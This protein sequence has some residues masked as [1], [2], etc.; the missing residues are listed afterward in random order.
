MDKF[1][2]DIFQVPA[3]LIA[4]FFFVSILLLNYFGYSLRKKIAKKNPERELELGT[5]EGS[6]LGLMGL[7]LAFSFG[8]A[9]TKYEARRQTIVDEANL[10]STAILRSELFPD[11]IRQQL[12]S[13]LRN[14]LEYRI[15]YFQAGDKPEKIQAS[16]KNAHHQ[17]R[18]LYSYSVFLTDNN[19]YRP[20]AEQ[21]IS[22]LISMRTIMVNR[23]AGRVAAVPGLIIIV[24]LLLVF[25]AS[26]LTGIGIKPGKRSPFL[27]LAFAF[28]TTVVLYLVMEL[29]RPREGI[30]N[31]QQAE[32]NL[33]DLRTLFTS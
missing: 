12:H 17:F 22:A 9:A 30:V 11:S 8:M 32:K 21:M 18:N 16:L 26:F 4:L 25:L 31:L 27:V 14:Y 33:E 10:I 13:E 19:E 7:L 28:M 24:L 2:E 6:L 3:L 23:E 20:R 5:G 1:R 15:S 29:S